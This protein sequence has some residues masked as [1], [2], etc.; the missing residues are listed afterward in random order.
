MLFLNLNI[1]TKTLKIISLSFTLAGVLFIYVSKYISLFAVRIV[2]AAVL[3]FSAINIKKS[4]KYMTAKEKTVCLLVIAA[5]IFGLFLPEF[6]MFV[7]GI[8]LLFL[9]VPVCINVIKTKDY[10]DIVML[11]INVAGILF[12]FYC[13]INSKAALNTVIIV[14][15]II[16]TIIGCLAM[17][18]TLL[19]EKNKR[20]EEKGY[21]FERFNF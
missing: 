13:I 6:I 19:R 3:I 17:Y 5:S 14:V 2:M 20:K 4:Y 15:G 11:I 9:T 16:L 21:G 7:I 10:S 8:L 1:K 18:E 12:A